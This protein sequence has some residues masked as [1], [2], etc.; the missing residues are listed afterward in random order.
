[1]NSEIVKN[2]S[3]DE[4]KEEIK[5]GNLSLISEHIDNLL[6]NSYYYIYLNGD[7]ISFP[8]PTILNQSELAKL[9]R[10]LK[11]DELLN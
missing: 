4:L 6:L 2:L 9:H 10:E 3:Y 7:G 1:M 8:M 5:S 11:I